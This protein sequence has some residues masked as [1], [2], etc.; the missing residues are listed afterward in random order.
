MF[1]EI[2]VKCKK[3]QTEYNI[4]VTDHT[5]QPLGKFICPD[6]GTKYIKE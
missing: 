3:C 2:L 4:T 1:K 5:N 6:C